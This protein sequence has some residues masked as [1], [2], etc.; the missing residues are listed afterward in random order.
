MADIKIDKASA[1][2]GEELLER[3]LVEKAKLIEGLTEENGE[4][5][6]EV[7]DLKSQIAKLE[8]SIQAQTLRINQLETIL[9]HTKIAQRETHFKEV[10]KVEEKL[11]FEEQLNAIDFSKF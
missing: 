10:P 4:L 1:L 11:S 9:D 5:K 7:L 3:E 8:K 2:S 6:T